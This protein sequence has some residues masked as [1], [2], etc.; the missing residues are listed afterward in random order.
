[1]NTIAL[2]VFSVTVLGIICAAMLAVASKVMAVKIDE[3]VKKLREFLPGANCGACGYSGC[4]GYAE[5]LANEDAITNL[6]TP[7]GD[8]VSQEI[9]AFLG[10]EVEDVIEA[11]AAVYCGG[12]CNSRQR[13]MDYSGIQTCAAAKQVYGGQNACAFGCLG[14][15][16][17]AAVCPSGAICIEDGLARI[18]SRRCVGC[19]LCVAA[20]PNSVIRM[21]YSGSTAAVLCRNT[22]KGAVV[23]N[24]CSKGCIGCMRC[25]K[26]C[27]A[28][29]I[30]V[31]DNLASVEQSKCTGCG[32]C[33]DVCVTKSIRF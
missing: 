5:A 2:A 14:F 18:D 23:R 17:C 7:G 26:E 25:V 16:D 10:V 22:E 6:C 1:M 32:K 13:K 4:D 3:R 9:S 24:K 15:G 11:V 12:D 28:E 27:P 33:A 20:C 29:A 21:D 8:K 19:R 30:S 31:I